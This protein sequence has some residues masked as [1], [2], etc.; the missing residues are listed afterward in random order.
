M[1]LRLLK[2]LITS[3]ICSL[4]IYL[5]FFIAIPDNGILLLSFLAFVATTGINVYCF[6]FDY[7]EKKYFLDQFLPYV[8]YI[9]MGFLTYLFLPLYVFNRIFL[10]LR[11]A[12]CFGYRISESIAITSAAFVVIIIAIRLIGVWRGKAF[13]KWYDER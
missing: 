5:G 8:I 4:A 2:I 11:F 7:W 3:I 10:P 1:L 13:D 6:T 9:V 12:G